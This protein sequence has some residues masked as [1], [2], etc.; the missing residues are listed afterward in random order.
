VSLADLCIRR[1]V[2]TLMLTLALVVFGV[3]GY[4][5]LGV[6]QFPSMEFPV[7]QVSALMEGA[8]PEV[9]EEDV[10]DTLEEYLN[11]VQGVRD[12]TSVTT[13][14]VTQITVTFELDKDLDVAAQDVRDKVALARHELPADVEPPLV[15]KF[16]VGDFP[17]LW[18]PLLSDRSV[19]DNTEFLKN[20]VKPRLETIDGVG[21]APLFGALERNIRIWLDGDALSARGL[22]AGDVIAALRREHV[23]IPG[24][25]VESREIEYSVK[26]DSE[27]RTLEELGGLVLAE[28]DGAPVHLRDVARIEDGAEDEKILARFNGE[29][30]I[31]IGILKQRGGNS[32]AIADETY[33]RTARMLGEMPTGLSFGDRKAAIDFTRAIREAVDETLFALYFGAVLAVLTVFVFLRR[34]RPT[35]IIATAIPLSI[36][37]TFG[38]MWLLDFTLN[39]MTLL[40]LTL[41]VGVVVDDAIVVLENIERHRELGESPYDAASKGTREIAFAATAAT[42]SIAAVFLP[43][44]FAEGVLGNFLREFG[45]TV[46]ASVIISLFVAL[47][48]TP[49]LAARMAPPKE[50]A[51]GSIYDYLERGF[52]WLERSYGRTLDWAL[53]HRGLVLGVALLS[54][55]AA[56]GFGMALDKEFFPPEDRGYFFARIETPPGTHRDATLEL[57]KRNESWM[58]QQP[59]V[60]GLFAAVGVAGP[61]T[62]EGASNVGIMFMTLKPRSERVRSVADLI[63]DG[64]EALNRIPGQRINLFQMSLASSSRGAALEF[65]VQGNLSLN[66]LDGLADQMIREL[67]NRSG[68]VDL[69]KSL[70]LGLPEL[71]VIPDR[72]KAAALGV[73]ATTMAQAVQAMIGGLDIATFKEAGRG[74]DI[75]VRLEREHRSEPE[76]IQ[77]LYVRGRGGELVELRN[78]VRIEKRAAPSAITRSDRQRSVTISSNLEGKAIAAAVAEVQQVARAVLPEGVRLAFS[79]EAEQLQESAQQMTL[80]LGLSILVIYM[81]LAM[82]FESLLHPLT[83]MLALPLAM[84][85]ALG[86][87]LAMDLLGR[88]GMTLNMF[89]MI[90]VILLFGLVTKNSIL[91]VDYANQLRE[92]GMDAEA[93]M[94]T[95]GPVRMRPVLMTAI[96]M[97][98]GVLPAAIGVGPGAESRAPMG[99]AT[100]VGML[101]ST[102]LT[103]VVVPVFYLA[104]E[105]ALAWVRSAPRKLASALR[106]RSG[107]ARRGGGL[108]GGESPVASPRSDR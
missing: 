83:I 66:E 84:T 26:T 99:V 15:Q 58:L 105:D 18:I 33:S 2:L 59:E 29:P 56:I 88:G 55:A 41:A 45:V 25:R 46:A 108:A 73:D 98:F 95:A 50:R 69:D 19:V 22:A 16:A 40:G 49:M 23:D 27:F 38:V 72:E 68:Y 75:R 57:L 17:I 9:M 85:G 8:S 14:G 100:G 102:A 76:A 97:I 21:A 13:E 44:A 35:L 37:A 10:T 103:L 106:R 63:R 36:V 89:S 53:G 52:T 51:H 74:Y 54:F 7:I 1:P 61:D 6:D 96:S 28:R 92:Q 90:G 104:I 87:L 24:G 81:T 34:M 42:F 71:R 30:A 82:Q 94:R 77:R 43:V 80:I 101:S 48:L 12:V 47:T 107:G 5:R 93:A 78:L 60:E 3:L 79:G 64:R 70:K 4:V 62:P 32:V 31:A 11:T 20:R 67:R 86:G 91:L 39:V 65:M